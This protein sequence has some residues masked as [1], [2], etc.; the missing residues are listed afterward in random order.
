MKLPDIDF[1]GALISPDGVYRY[2]LER[3]W[4]GGTLTSPCLLWCMLN[5]STADSNIDDHDPT[6]KR[7]VGFSNQW[8]FKRLIVVNLY[9]YR[10]TKPRDLEGLSRDELEG[11]DNRDW[12]YYYATNPNVRGIVCAWGSHRYR[13]IPVPIEI[14]AARHLWALSFTALGEPGHPLYLPADSKLVRIN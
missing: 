5:P 9:A 11:P 1:R 4:S 14:S 12:L 13:C 8:G 10:A 6:I 7:C 2:W 3:R